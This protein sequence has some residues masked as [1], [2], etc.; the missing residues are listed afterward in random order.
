MKKSIEEWEAGRENKPVEEMAA[1][2]SSI[3]ES[4]EGAE[5]E[6][7]M[8]GEQIAIRTNISEDRRD[9][10]ALTFFALA[11]SVTQ[12]TFYEGKMSYSGFMALNELVEGT[13]N[14]F[15][16]IAKEADQIQFESS[17]TPDKEKIKQMME[18][19]TPE[20]QERIAR[21]MIAKMFGEQQ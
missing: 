4:L 9:M 11:L 14:A 3:L 1:I 5:V 17:R 8:Q 7:K 15:G 12:Q 20:Q 16:E 19:L 21:D 18:G 10:L 2:S 13:K 6:A